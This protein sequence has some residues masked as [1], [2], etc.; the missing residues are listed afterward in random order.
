MA[1]LT[2][3]ARQRRWRKWIV[4]ALIGAMAAP[5]CTGRV[6]RNLSYIGPRKA[7][8]DYFEDVATRIEYPD[9]QE[10]LADSVVTTLEPRTLDAPRKDEVWDIPLQEAIHIA[11]RNNR[12]IR[13]RNEFLAGGQLFNN[14]LGAPSVYDP[15]IR[16]SGVLFGG[17]GVESAL[18]AFDTTL[19][20]T[21]QTGRNHTIQ[22]ILFLGPQAGGILMQN[23]AQAQMGLTKNL[24]YGATVGVTHNWNFLN[25]NQQFIGFP[26]SFNGLTQ[27][28]Y[29]QPLWAGAGAQFTRI[30]GPIGTNILG[31]SGVNQGV[32]IARINTDI[33]LA[34]FEITT[35][36]LVRD[37]EDLYWELYLAY[38]TYDSTVINRNSAL[39]TWREAETKRVVGATG[40]GAADVAQAQEAYFNARASAEDSLQNLYS[41]EL[42]LRRLIGLPVNDG[43]ILRPADEPATA[44]FV[45]EWRL[46]LTDALTRREEIRRQKWNVKSL[47][48]QLVAA[49]NL[50]APRLDF[51]SSYQVNGFG[52]RLFGQDD[53]FD[54]AAGNML[55]RSFYGNMFAA[56]QTGW[57]LGLQF[58]MPLGLRNSLAQVR[59]HELQLTKAKQVLATQ[60]FE[61]SH[62]LSNAFQTLAWRYKTAQ[63]NFNRRI[64]AEQQ[65]KAREA[66]YL[67]GK[68]TLDP[69]L[70][71][72][73]GMAQADIAY[74][75]SLVRYNQAL[76]DLQLRK[77]TLL[78]TNNIH[79]AESSWTPEAYKEAWRRSWARTYAI[80]APG[81][82][83]IHAEPEPV[84]ADGVVGTTEFADPRPGESGTSVPDPEG[85]RLPTPSPWSDSAIRP[86]SRPLPSPTTESVPR[87][88]LEATDE[89]AP[90]RVRRGGYDSGD[91]LYPEPTIRSVRPANHL[92]T[93]RPASMR[94]RR[95]FDEPP[96]SGIH[97]KR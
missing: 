9:V 16:E 96:S 76:T 35:R 92:E 88:R 61:V 25:T 19:T 94:R 15:A 28:T 10:P 64:A 81:W 75:T 50:A 59:N 87:P 97:H 23:T 12:I 42:Q 90:R 41:T 69:L 7:T 45:P 36:N 58:S 68:E 4:T 54:A 6:E 60:E 29:Q 56:E 71:A 44:E 74:F 86:E 26:S 24:G 38:R 3:T 93:D 82:D 80:E 1:F 79:L 14:P 66:L 30:A 63:T 49:R 32:L 20:G 83:P 31:V 43:K 17:R 70:R 57:G 85:E 78:E 22:N 53:F 73:A 37:V 18:A 77:G 27:L 89:S 65:L 47:E 62:E 72:Q 67:A 40:G 11:L 52:R 84:V 95:G 55:P 46:C 5:G 13:T 51:V 33:S 21:L 34:D 48:L 91:D 2:A 8:A 39:R